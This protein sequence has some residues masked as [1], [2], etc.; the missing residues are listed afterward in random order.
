MDKQ[1]YYKQLFYKRLREV[2]EQKGIGLHVFAQQSG[3][4]PEKLK[5]YIYGGVIPRYQDLVK[6]CLSLN[7]KSDYLLG[8]IDEPRP[9]V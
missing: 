8:L 1:L 4:E 2:F 6:I 5:G 3:I 9:I 7:V